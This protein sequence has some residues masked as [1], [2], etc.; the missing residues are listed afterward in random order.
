MTALGWLLLAI[1]VFDLASSLPGALSGHAG[2]DR[3]MFWMTRLGE[4]TPLDMAAAARSPWWPVGIAMTAVWAGLEL[5]HMTDRH[6][7]AATIYGVVASVATIYISWPQ[8][9]ALGHAFRMVGVEDALGSVAGF[10][11][12]AISLVLPVATA[13][14]ANRKLMPTAQARIR[15]S[16]NE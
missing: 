6:R 12:L 11:Q 10:M 14:L 16:G 8:L 7:V 2:L 1:G 15:V 9:E 13:V 5:V 4:Q 3:V